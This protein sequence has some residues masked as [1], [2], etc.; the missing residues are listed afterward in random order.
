[1]SMDSLDSNNK[2]TS[3]ISDYIF[4]AR[5]IIGDKDIIALKANQALEKVKSLDPQL[6]DLIEKVI[7]FTEIVQNY[8]NGSYR[9]VETKTLIF[10]IAAILYFLNPFDI[11][12]DVLPLIGF[13]DDA[14]VLL[15][16]FS[17]L[18]KEIEK[19]ETWK[20]TVELLQYESE[21]EL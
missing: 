1:M 21:R 18:N 9:N 7:L 2:F 12:P 6:K 14:A 17:K 5:Q 19:Y 13:T 4:K 15:F 3:K 8:V 10:I 11:I 20:T 16:V